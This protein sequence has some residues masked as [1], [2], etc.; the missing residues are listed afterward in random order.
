MKRFE[1]DDEA[2]ACM[3]VYSG[4]QNYEHTSRQSGSYTY[5]T[6]LESIL[7]MAIVRNSFIY[8]KSH[9]KHSSHE[10]N[11]QNRATCHMDACN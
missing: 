4:R 9:W 1:V 11:N 5:N 7:N 2:I 10:L 8:E 3:F 6:V